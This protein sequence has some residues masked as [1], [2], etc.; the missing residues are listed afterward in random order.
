MSTLTNLL[1]SSSSS[2]R[3]RPFD[4]RRDLRP[5]ADLVERCFAETLDQE[6]ER[7]LQQM[8]S[9]ANNPSFLRWAAAAAEGSSVPMSGYVWEEDGQVVGNISLIPYTIHGQRLYLIANVATHPNYRRRG[10]A[11][12]LTSHSIE[13]ARRRGAPAAWLHVREENAAAVNLYLELGFEERARRTT[14]HSSSSIPQN[15]ALPGLV[16]GPRRAQHWG[17]QLAW[18]RSTY[19]P[20]VTWHLPLN[21]RALR[22]GWQGTLYRFLAAL[23]A[24]QY[25]LQRDGRLLGALSWQPTRTYADMLWLAAGPENEAEAAHAL[26]LYARQQLSPRRRLSLDYPAGRAAEAIEAAGFQRHQTLIWME[27]GLRG[28][29]G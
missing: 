25:V 28:P 2:G 14:W 1:V 5:V 26:L 18:L 19:P 22:P 16:I 15:T 24:W 11:R 12:K 4:M 23:P 10:I 7:Y 8:R 3:L 29:E 6:G 20:D 9:A 21:L 13:H 27:V 17:K